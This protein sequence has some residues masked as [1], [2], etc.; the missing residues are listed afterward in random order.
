MG[1]FNG[2]IGPYQ[3]PDIASMSRG[4]TGNI[5][6]SSHEDPDFGTPFRGVT[7]GCLA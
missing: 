7:V 4:F 1:F 6:T 2:F 5:A 3:S